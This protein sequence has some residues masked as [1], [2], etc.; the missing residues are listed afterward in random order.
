[1]VMVTVALAV[2][3]AL[4]LRSL[5]ERYPARRGALAWGVGAALVFE[6]FP[7][8]RTL[9]TA[10]VPR[11]YDRVAADPRPMV[12]VLE[13]P[14][15]LRDGTSSFGSFT[16][17][18]LFYQTAH[19]KA[20]F[21]GY[22]SRLSPRHVDATRAVPLLGAFMQLSEG[23]PATVTAGELSATVPDFIAQTQLGYVVIDRARASD[24]LIALASEVLQLEWLGEDAGLE[25]YRPARAPRSLS[26]QRNGVR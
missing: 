23:R 4:A 16:A 1:M 24:A 17:R 2:L 12:T 5:R 19:G 14:F 10:V 25:L 11:I 6:L 26:E 15:G 9:S 18:T 3:F 22:L 20:I 7:A 8:P 21:G 13:L